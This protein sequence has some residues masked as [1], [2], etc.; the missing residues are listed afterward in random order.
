[1]TK[2]RMCSQR[3]TRPGRLCRE[4][5]RELGRERAAADGFAAVV[6]RPGSEGP[7]P[8]TATFGASRSRTVALFA[9]FAIGIGIAASA[10][11]VQGARSAHDGGASVMIDRDLSGIKPREVRAPS[12]PQRAAASAA[13]AV[14]HS[15]SPSYDRV[16]GLADALDRCSGAAPYARL[17]CEAR[18]RAVYCGSAGADRIPQCLTPR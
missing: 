8:E 2:C 18:A 6:E 7:G 3:L 14:A 17:A 4:C 1:M 5:E 16:L 12:Q 13:I 15:P 10:Y 11:V 9:A